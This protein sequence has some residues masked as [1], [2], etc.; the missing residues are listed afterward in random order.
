MRRNWASDVNGH[1][2]ESYAQEIGK[3]D[4]SS[5]DF[6]IDYSDV[7]GKLSITPCSFVSFDVALNACKISNCAIDLAAWRAVMIACSLGNSP[8]KNVAVYHCTITQQHVTDLVCMLEKKVEMDAIKI[9]NCEWGTDSTANDVLGIL[10]STKA[11]VHYMSFRYNG[12]DDSFVSANATALSQNLFLQFLNLSNNCITDEGLQTLATNVLRCNLSLK[13]VSLK[14]NLI[15][16]RSL[17]PFIDLVFG[18]VCTSE[19]DTAFKVIA[20]AAA[21]KN[22]QIKDVNKKRKKSNE[23]EISE[24]EVPER[25][26]KIGKSDLQLINKTILEIDISWNKV[27]TE[28]IGAFVEMVTIRKETSPDVE[29]RVIPRA[30]AATHNSG[31][32]DSTSSVQE[33]FS[34]LI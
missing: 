33:G 19:E 32:R 25:V 16:G 7:C 20:K 31:D 6:T 24:V 28:I 12:L 13:K 21:D 22:K 11:I 34:L 18:S 10:L 17:S 23:P 3:N 2:L 27:S 4:V 14:N 5:G 15:E 1:E 26:V 29:V 30:A 9:D 8:V